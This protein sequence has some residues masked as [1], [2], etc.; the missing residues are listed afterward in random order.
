MPL[1]HPAVRALGALLEKART[2]PDTYPLSMQALVAACN[3]KT[4]RE[5]VTD[6]SEREVGEAMQQL[7]DR[8][9]AATVRR[10]GDRVPKHRHR[11]GDAIGLSA[12]EEA[13]VSVLMLRGPQT[14]GEL[15]TRTERYGGMLSPATIEATLEGLAQR[16]P[17]MVVNRGRGPGQSQDRWEHTLGPREEDRRPRVRE[18]STSPDAE[19]VREAGTADATMDDLVRRIEALEERVARLEHE[20]G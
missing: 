11:L 10:A 1:S 2:T 13:I 4:A 5:P 7:R 8:G 14:V 6:L 19:H 12:P 16:K 3:Q 17:P 18:A 20:E 9:L 15:R